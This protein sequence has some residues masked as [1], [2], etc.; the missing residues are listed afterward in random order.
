MTKHKS[1]E[2]SGFLGPGTEF[3][4]VLR[5]TDTM[6]VEGTFRGRIE[7]PEAN[8]VVAE[9]GAVRADIDVAQL[10]VAGEVRGTVQVRRRLE[11]SR[12]G[13]ISGDVYAPNLIIREGA[14]LDGVCHMDGSPPPRTEDKKEPALEEAAASAASGAEVSDPETE[15]PGEKEEEASP[16]V[17]T[18]R[19][20]KAAPPRESRKDRRRRRRREREAAETPPQE[21]SAPADVAD[22]VSAAP[23]WRRPTWETPADEPPQQNAKGGTSTT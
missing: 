2:L 19:A 8:L 10:Y 18:E 16:E 9:G 21:E 23:V 17:D 12:K 11:I 5:F 6:R 14:V 22:S 4:G 1:P 13:A 15:D 3:E 7:S 20:R